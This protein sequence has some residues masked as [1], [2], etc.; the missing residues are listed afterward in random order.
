MAEAGDPMVQKISE[1]VGVSKESFAAAA[2]DAVQTA[3]KSLR[4]L[5]WF[6]ATEFEGAVKNGKIVEYHTTVRLYFDY[7]E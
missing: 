3:S 5:K 4:N 1:V 6:R 2:Q 7:E